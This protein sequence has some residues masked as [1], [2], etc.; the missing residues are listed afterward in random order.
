MMKKN[1]EDKGR[2]QTQK[3]WDQNEKRRV[4]LQQMSRLWLRTFFLTKTLMDLFKKYE[5]GKKII[6]CDFH[7]S[8]VAVGEEAELR[9]MIFVKYFLWNL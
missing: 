6:K 5:W 9:E 7:F 8:F 3:K 4:F 2:Q 1:I